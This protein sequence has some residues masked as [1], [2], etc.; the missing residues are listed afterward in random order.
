MIS[1]AVHA[2]RLLPLLHPVFCFLHAGSGFTWFHSNWADKSVVS[3][4]KLSLIC[5]GIRGSSVLHFLL[6]I[7]HCVTWGHT[8]PKHTDLFKRQPCRGRHA[9]TRYPVNRPTLSH[10]RS[11]RN[12]YFFL[13]K[14]LT[15]KKIHNLHVVQETFLYWRR[16]LLICFL[17]NLLEILWAQPASSAVLTSAL[18]WVRS[19]KRHGNKNVKYSPKHCFLVMDSL[20]FLYFFQMA[21]PVCLGVL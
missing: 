6:F 10:F 12:I 2:C 20:F 8:L 3:R 21:P 4:I 19:E 9:N 11:K 1:A 5:L 16:I 14:L 13:S 7:H 17:F 15:E 18:K